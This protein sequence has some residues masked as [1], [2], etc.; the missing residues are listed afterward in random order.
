MGV[1]PE[2]DISDAKLKAEPVVELEPEAEAVGVPVADGIVEVSAEAL[3]VGDEG[4]SID[5]VEAES[6]GGVG[7]L[8]GIMQ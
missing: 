6:E 3:G 2:E 7:D 4:V 8:A 5:V 1:I